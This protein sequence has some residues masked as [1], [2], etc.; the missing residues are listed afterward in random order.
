GADEKGRRVCRGRHGVDPV[1]A[2]EGADGVELTVRR[3]AVQGDEEL[4]R[5]KADNRLVGD[6][7][8]RGGTVERHQPVAN[9]HAGEEVGPRG[10]GREQNRGG[11]GRGTE[12]GTE[13]E[14]SFRVAT[15]RS[16]AGRK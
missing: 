8:V 9:R 16:S 12:Y 14:S 1:Q 10:A 2:V 4:R 6:R 15:L 5:L 11:D 13:H 7:D 3:S